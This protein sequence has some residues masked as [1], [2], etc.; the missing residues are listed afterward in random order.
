MEFYGRHQAGVETPPQAH[1][2]FLAL[3]LNDGVDAG[4]IRRLLTLLSDDAAALTQGTPPLA[5]T[6]PELATRPAGLTVT[7]GFGAGLVG[8]VTKA[9]T[10]LAAL[11]GFD[12]DKLELA[13]TRGD[14]LLQVCSDDPATVAHTVRMLIKDA[15][16]FTTVAWTRTGFRRAYGSD[17]AGATV[18]NPFGQVDGT[19]NPAPGSADFAR[20]VWGDAGSG[21]FGVRGE[22][23]L[24]LADHYPA[25]LAG[26]TT[27]VLRDI[28]MNL[29]TWDMA[30]RPA[31]E[32]AV[33]RTM[34]TGAPLTGTREHD[35]P[36][37]NARN[38]LG[39]TVISPVSHVAR[40]RNTADAAEQIYR[41]VYSYQDD[42]GLNAGL[43]FASYQANVDRQFL[44]IQR[45]LAQVDLL[46][47]WTTPVG[48][49]VWAIP[50]G[51]SAGGFVGETLFA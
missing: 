33:G 7:F 29:D 37:L 22:V 48:S 21:E 23:P 20:L 50:P 45:R 13:R 43:M 2:L 11:P 9:P 41:R 28:A 44:P 39:L 40:S 17:P 26:G 46:N 1:A 31:R 12:I 14:L 36:D 5:D 6:E 15:R 47:E 18:R 25:W 32:F 51:A 8:R 30:D 10:W 35:V 24:G 3:S 38:E 42:A 16:S 4:G 27:L 34:D 49:T 19:A